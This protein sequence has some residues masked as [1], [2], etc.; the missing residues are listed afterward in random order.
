MQKALKRI[1]HYKGFIAKEWL[2]LGSFLSLLITSLFF[3]RLPVYSEKEFQVVFVLFVF[4]ITVKG[5]ERSNLMLRFSQLIE[6]GRF[7]EIKFV[8]ATFLLSM[9]VTNDVALVMLVPLT[10]M[11]NV[12][13]KGVLVILEALAA[14]AGSA[15]T[16]FGNPQNL[17]I[18]WIYGVHPATFI[19]SIAPFS[20][21]FLILISLA[22]WLLKG[23]SVAK[24]PDIN[25]AEISSKAYSYLLL[26]AVLILVILHLLPVFMVTAVIVYALI[27]DRKSLKVDYA[28]LL[29]FV[30]F[31]GLADNLKDF[32]STEIG[33]TAN[34]FLYTAGLSQLISNV[35]ATLLLSKYT[36][37]WEALLWGSNVGGFGTLVASLANLIA[38][39]IYLSHESSK[40]K[41]MSF[42]LLFMVMGFAAL[43]IG[44]GLYF[45]IK[46][47][48]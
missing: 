31:F 45:L 27:F 12:E 9:F 21:F 20:V 43:L 14:N 2:F 37:Q 29:T 8:L 44:I 7:I 46:N 23:N 42:T 36:S 48:V 30:C 47:Y 1:N 24:S 33:S 40:S 3:Q 10:L 25:S 11:V 38:Y 28:L 16:P 22:T 5:L 34:I 26:L 17:F 41:K 6:A 19:L 4:F 15:L 35:P 32:F 39:K 13:R 18:Y